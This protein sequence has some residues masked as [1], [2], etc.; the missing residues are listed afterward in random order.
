M[1]LA[2][3]LRLP[4]LLRLQPLLFLYQRRLE[5]R[6][7]SVPALLRRPLGLLLL[8]EQLL[9]PRVFLREP[10]LVLFAP[11]LLAQACSLCLPSAHTVQCGD[12]RRAL[13]LEAVRLGLLTLPQRHLLL[14]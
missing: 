9:T 4:V 8:L 12:P 5:F 2:K 7:L 13:F 6:L 3:D 1:L 14:G 10:L 11:L